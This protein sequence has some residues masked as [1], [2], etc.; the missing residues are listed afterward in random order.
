MM[1]E[2]Y[3]DFQEIFAADPPPG[4][5]YDPFVVTD[6]GT[7][8]APEVRLFLRNTFVNIPASLL[9]SSRELVVLLSTSLP[10]L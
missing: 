8:V 3:S 9:A 1:G 6:E 7:Y 2:G 10:N 5:F 4:G